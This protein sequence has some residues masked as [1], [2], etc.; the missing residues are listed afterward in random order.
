MM[1]K[2]VGKFSWQSRKKTKH[3]GKIARLVSENCQNNL[4]K[5]KTVSGP[6]LLFRKFIQMGRTE[7]SGS[8]NFS[9]RGF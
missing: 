8:Q 6:S 2:G 5:Y 9:E 4:E 3:L 1:M 7:P